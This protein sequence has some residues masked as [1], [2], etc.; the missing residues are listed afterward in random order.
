MVK[1]LMYL[2]HFFRASNITTK[3]V[4]G[5]FPANISYSVPVLRDDPREK[6][7][8]NT[9][10]RSKN[11]P[12]LTSL[13]LLQWMCFMVAFGGVLGPTNLRRL[14]QNTQPTSC[15]TFSLILHDKPIEA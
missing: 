7:I 5:K 8:Y 11:L 3:L 9:M 10:S 6:T 12:D 2:R 4:K 14:S 1:I 15:D 13:I